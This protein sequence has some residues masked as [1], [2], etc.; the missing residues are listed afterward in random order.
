MRQ[1]EQTKSL[2]KVSSKSS[3]KA[4]NIKTTKKQLDPMVSRNH[5]NRKRSKAS[6]SRPMMAQKPHTQLLI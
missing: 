1:G 3:H 5:G 4:R 6:T 2:G